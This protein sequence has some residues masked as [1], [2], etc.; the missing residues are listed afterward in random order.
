MRSY[1]CCPT[2]RSDACVRTAPGAVAAAALEP[3]EEDRVVEV[4]V[5]ERATQQLQR[6]AG[7]RVGVLGVDAE[8]LG[9]SG[10]PFAE[11]E[12]DNGGGAFGRRQRGQRLVEPGDELLV[13]DALA[14]AHVVG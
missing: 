3:A 2:T 7:E 13:G 9:D 6:V 5:A 12:G 1:G 11:P 10:V 4:D 8:L 14:G